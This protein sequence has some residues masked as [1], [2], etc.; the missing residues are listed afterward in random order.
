MPEQDEPTPEEGARELMN[1]SGLA[2]ALGVTR[3]W[4][5]ALRVKDP[6]FPPAERLPGSTREVWDLK[7]V[8]A[9]YEGREKRPGERTDLK[10][11]PPAE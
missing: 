3:Q 9:Y 8:R 10:D 11:K 7:S 2:S 5:H 6:K 1:M 4:L